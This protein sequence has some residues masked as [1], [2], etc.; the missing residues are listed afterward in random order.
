M[1]DSMCRFI[2][3]VEDNARYRPDYPPELL[4]LLE[5]YATDYAEIE[6]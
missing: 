6:L 3:R 2:G 1:T 5:N 4:D